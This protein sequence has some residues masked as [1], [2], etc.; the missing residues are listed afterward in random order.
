MKLPDQVYMPLN[1]ATNV[2]F[3]DKNEG[4]AIDSKVN[5]NGTANAVEAKVINGH[6]EQEAK[7]DGCLTSGCR[8]QLHLDIFET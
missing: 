8:I 5:D 1:I 3:K 6:T 2:S 4:D 7:D